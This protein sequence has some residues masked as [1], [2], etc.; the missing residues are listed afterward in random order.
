VLTPEQLRAADQY[1]FRSIVER[2]GYHLMPS[3]LVYADDTYENVPGLPKGTIPK[4]RQLRH[5]LRERLATDP[6]M[7]ELFELKR[8][9]GF[10][11]ADV[12]PRFLGTDPRLPRAIF[13]KREHH[14]RKTEDDALDLLGAETVALLVKAF[15]K[16]LLL[17]F[18]T[19]PSAPVVKPDVSLPIRADIL[20]K[21]GLTGAQETELRQLEANLKARVEAATRANDSA[22][23]Q[24]AYRWF[25]REVPSI[26]T[27]EQRVRWQAAAQ[28]PE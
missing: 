27:E 6:G 20:A 15:P 2:A 8:K 3:Y 24:D 17:R 9:E 25:R 4:V 11:Y 28:A 5:E 14:G 18:Q 10:L 26:L 23:V 16:P 13:E 21:L 12:M 7:R 1:M 19:R 22:A